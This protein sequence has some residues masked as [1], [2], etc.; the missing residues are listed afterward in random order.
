MF[1]AV[2][3]AMSDDQQRAYWMPLINNHKILGC[4]AQ[5]ELGHG[6]N[7]AQLETTATLDLKTDEFIIHSPTLTSIKYWPGDMGRFTTHACVFARAIV[8]DKDYGV[9]AFIV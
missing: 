8:G 4:Y 6:S 3:N 5:T 7:V 1:Q 2:V 9:H